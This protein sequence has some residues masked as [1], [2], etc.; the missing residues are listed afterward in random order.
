[1]DTLIVRSISIPS[2]LYVLPIEP[3]SKLRPIPL[4]YIIEVFLD[5]PHLSLLN[6]SFSFW[7]VVRCFANLTLL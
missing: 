2:S 1:M 5:A 7:N 4:E 6:I 3:Y